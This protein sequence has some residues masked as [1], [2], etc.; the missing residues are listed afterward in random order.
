M[1][2][3]HPGALLLLTLLGLASCTEMPVIRP[4]SVQ[5]ARKLSSARHWQL[6]AADLKEQVDNI[7]STVTQTCVH[8]RSTDQS[9][10]S[11]FQRFLADAITE[12]ILN[13]AALKT[14]NR[15]VLWSTQSQ[16]VSST[17]TGLKVFRGNA[18]S[19]CDDILIDSRVIVHNGPPGRPYPGQFTLL[20]GGLVV[21]RN[22]ARAFSAA[23]G[24]GLVALAETGFWASSGF[25]SGSTVTE[26]TVTI[27]RL[28]A[29]NQYVSEFTNVYYINS[30]D[31]KLYSPPPPPKKFAAGISPHPQE[32]ADEAVHYAEQAKRL[33]PAR[34]DIRPNTV[35]ACDTTVPLFITGAYLSHLE[36]AYQFGTVRGSQFGVVPSNWPSNGE[37]QTV[38]VIFTGVSNANKALPAIPVSMEGTDGRAAVGYVY[39]DGTSACAKSTQTESKTKPTHAPSPD[40]VLAPKGKPVGFPVNVCVLP[41]EID[42]VEKAGA[43]IAKVE[44][45]DG[46]VASVCSN[47]DHGAGKAVTFTTLPDYSKAPPKGS[48]LRIKISLEGGKS[49]EKQIN[50]EC[51]A[52]K[53][54]KPVDSGT[55]H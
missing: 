14:A 15:S 6:I 2:T 29:S 48:L 37:I 47:P 18:G 26:L 21:A 40:V 50:A 9:T 1:T 4:N 35:S 23:S 32:D 24:V 46:Y 49:L 28:T 33:A 51:I 25:R 7:D 52:G 8:V 45:V 30:G 11:T 36:H 20:A 16:K 55:C 31:S 27:S 3:F 39:L 54:A 41:V 34:L 22:V 43:Q 38:Q 53:P 42:A 17:P 10:E 13:P 19:G 5:D 12:Q 44:T